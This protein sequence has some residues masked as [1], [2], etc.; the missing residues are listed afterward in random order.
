MEQMIKWYTP[1]V[2]AA[3]I[4]AVCNI[5]EMIKTV[6]EGFKHHARQRELLYDGKFFREANEKR[7]REENKKNHSI[8]P[9]YILT[10]P[11][12]KAGYAFL[13]L[14]YYLIDMWPDNKIAEKWRK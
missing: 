7:I 9:D 14:G 11:G 5:S 12:R 4:Y 6:N 1:I 8:G 2:A 10:N 13:D 3:S